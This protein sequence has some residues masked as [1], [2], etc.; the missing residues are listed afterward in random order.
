MP[1][2]FSHHA[3]AMMMTAFRNSDKHIVIPPSFSIKHQ[4]FVMMRTRPSERERLIHTLQSRGVPVSASQRAHA[5][6]T[7][8]FRISDQTHEFAVPLFLANNYYLVMK[9]SR[10]NGSKVY[11]YTTAAPRISSNRGTN[12]QPG[13][14]EMSLVGIKYI[15]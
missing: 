1:S 7:W 9:G 14:F 3:H 4:Y 15:H 6:F 8:V 12:L 10:T 5:S 11:I 13:S 2:P